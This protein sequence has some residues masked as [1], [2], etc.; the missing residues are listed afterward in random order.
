[1][2]FLKRCTKCNKL[3]T[4]KNKVPTGIEIDL[5]INCYRENLYA[6]LTTFKLRNKD[7]GCCTGVVSI[8]ETPKED[9][10]A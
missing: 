9:V 3:L 2:F 8:D 5:C 6:A 7:D 1:M 10:N 4:R